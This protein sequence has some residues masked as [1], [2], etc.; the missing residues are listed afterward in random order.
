MLFDGELSSKTLPALATEILL[1]AN[2]CRARSPIE[3]IHAAV[4]PAGIEGMLKAES[5]RNVSSLTLVIVQGIEL[6]T[7]VILR[8]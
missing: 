5:I 8:R 2:P 1:P 6:S 4:V 7:P 3:L